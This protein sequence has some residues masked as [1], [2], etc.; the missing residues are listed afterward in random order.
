M[1]RLVKHYNKKIKNFDVWDIKL[2]KWSTIFFILFILKLI[3]PLKDWVFTQNIWVF[4]V[5]GII[6]IIRPA[7]KFF[8]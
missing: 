3:P 4:L 8:G 2:I 7:K 6:T 5:L 1:K